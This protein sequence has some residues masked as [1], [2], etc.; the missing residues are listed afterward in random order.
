MI[1]QKL[2]IYKYKKNELV[3]EQTNKVSCALG[4][5]SVQY[6]QISY[7]TCFSRLFAP[8]QYDHVIPVCLKGNMKP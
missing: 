4:K 1:H 8:A 2:H 5:T 6:L 3:H 7:G